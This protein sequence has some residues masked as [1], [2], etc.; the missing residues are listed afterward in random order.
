MII[1][2]ELLFII[3]LGCLLHFT[4]EWS[5]HNK[6][7]GWFSAV[8]ESTWEHIKITVLPIFLTTIMDYW[9]FGENPNYWF[10]KFAMVLFSVVMLPAIFYLIQAILKKTIIIMDIMIFCLVVVYSVV[11]F[12]GILLTGALGLETFGQVGCIVILAVFAFSTFFPMK[13]FLFM[14]PRN[15]KCGFLGHECHHAHKRKK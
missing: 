13:N 1:L 14:D 12:N 6:L 8:N 10:A 7:V 2:L 11:V 4:Y 5:H 3:I 9:S 15:K